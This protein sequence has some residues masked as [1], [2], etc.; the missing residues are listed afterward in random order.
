[1]IGQLLQYCKQAVSTSY[2]VVLRAPTNV[3]SLLLTQR[4]RTVCNLPLSLT[5][6]LCVCSLSILDSTVVELVVCSTV[7]LQLSDLPY[8]YGGRKWGSSS[9]LRLGLAL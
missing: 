1:M 4:H 3:S 7:L 5:L 6:S 2:G 9:S 8:R